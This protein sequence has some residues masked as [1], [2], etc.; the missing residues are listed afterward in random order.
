[1]TRPLCDP[2]FSVTLDIVA[3]FNDGWIKEHQKEEII[4]TGEISVPDILRLGKG[5][6]LTLH[7]ALKYTETRRKMVAKALNL[8]EGDVPEPTLKIKLKNLSSFKSLFAP[9]TRDYF[10]GIK[11]D[12]EN[13]SKQYFKLGFRRIY[14]IVAQVK[15][16]KNQISDIFNFK[17]P[18]FSTLCFFLLTTFIILFDVSTVLPDFMFLLVLIALYKSPPMNKYVLPYLEEWFFGD[19][20]LNPYYQNPCVTTAGDQDIKKSMNTSK[21]K[22]KFR[23]E[24]SLVTTF[25]KA[26]KSLATMTIVLNSVSSFFEKFKNI[27]SWEDPTRTACFIA[28]LMFAYCALY[29]IGLRTM[30]LLAGKMVKLLV[31]S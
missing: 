22:E 24:E 15:I 28:F 18:L 2:F 1:M 10:E 14:R 23:N 7:L 29:A 27:L 17:Y 12:K 16:F 6:V 9:S 8:N 26:K 25:K 13:Y 19:S 31:N 4:C 20:H 21:W 30:I 11:L 5:E 3:V